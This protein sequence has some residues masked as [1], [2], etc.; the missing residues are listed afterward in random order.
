MLDM[1]D[2]QS[3]NVELAHPNTAYPRFNELYKM[4]YGRVSNRSRTSFKHH[5][6]AVDKERRAV[7]RKMVSVLSPSNLSM[8]ITRQPAPITEHQVD[9]QQPID[10]QD[11]VDINVWPE[12]TNASQDDTVSQTGTIAHEK[13]VEESTIEPPHGHG[14]LMERSLNPDTLLGQRHASVGLPGVAP[15]T[16]DVD[17]FQADSYQ[18]DPFQGNLPSTLSIPTA[19]VPSHTH[20]G[21]SSAQTQSTIQP[22]WDAIANKTTQS[23]ISHQVTNT[24]LLWLPVLVSAAHNAP[25][26]AATGPFPP[27]RERGFATLGSCNTSHA[28]S[29]AGNATLAAQYTT[30]SPF[31][32]KTRTIDQNFGSRTPTKRPFCTCSAPTVNTM[33][34]LA[35]RPYYLSSPTASTKVN[36]P[37]A[38]ESTQSMQTQFTNCSAANFWGGM[39]GW[40]WPH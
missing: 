16:Q 18:S 15:G 37:L 36:W 3:S 33:E 4:R 29:G 19:P 24:Q 17:P 1:M 11:E 27:S 12:E 32:A 14:A 8:L 28:I 31:C 26:I 10:W 5:Y 38:P 35:A 7:D 2:G 25:T 34:S 40:N 13:H 30:E 21:W 20:M 22:S 9:E 23:H 6:E 39:Q